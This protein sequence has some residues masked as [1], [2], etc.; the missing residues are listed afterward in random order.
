MV[1]TKKKRPP[2]L[3]FLLHGK[4]FLL[5][6]RICVP[7]PP[8]CPYP[9]R[10]F[11]PILLR[12][13]HRIRTL[14]AMAWCWMSWG[15]FC[16]FLPFIL[17]SFCHFPTHSQLT[18]WLPFPLQVLFPSTDLRAVRS[19]ITF[20]RASSEH[21][22]N[23]GEQHGSEPLSL[24]SLFIF[25]FFNLKAAWAPF[26]KSEP[27]TCRTQKLCPAPQPAPFCGSL[28]RGQDDAQQGRAAGGPCQNFSSSLLLPIFF[29]LY[30]L[31]YQS[32]SSISSIDFS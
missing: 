30:L 26:Q 17:P 19:R 2:A 29:P 15:S 9:W 7:L 22:P 12:G 10:C 14:P 5:L 32:K 31:S 23:E 16:H 3:R 25:Y 4:K 21:G 1:D 11:V 8:R 28:F 27:L 20:R 13:A 24:L 6:P 18:S